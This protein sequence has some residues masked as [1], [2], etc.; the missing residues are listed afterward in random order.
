MKRIIVKCT[1]TKTNKGVA[2]DIHLFTKT[3]DINT[4]C[5]ALQDIFASLILKVRTNL[6]DI[7]RM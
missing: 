4:H 2:N 1:R 3:D 6:W 5:Y 7:E